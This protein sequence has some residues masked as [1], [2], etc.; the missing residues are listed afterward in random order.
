MK[1]K[2]AFA[3]II[4]LLA[5]CKEKNRYI[6]NQGLIY[7]TIYHITYQS[8]NGNDL[9][10]GIEAVL[11][12]IGNSV[13]TFIPSATISKVN[14][15]EDT[16]LDP[17]FLTVFNKAQEVSRITD[18]AF[19]VTVMPMVNAWGF[20]F[21]NKEKVTPELIDSLKQLVGYQ[22]VRIENGKFVKDHPNTM[23]DFSAIAKGFACD[24]VGQFLQVQGCKNYMVEIGGEVVAKGQNEKGEYW[25]IGIS[26]PDDNEMLG[27]QQLNAIVHLKDMA[28][29]TSGNYRN[30][31]IED[32]I[33]Y[34][35]EIDP[36]TG[37]PARHSVLSTTVLAKDC[38][39]AD[40]FATAFM[41]CGLDKA[42]A[43]A[44]A[45]SDIEVYF[46]YVGEDGKYKSYISP[47]FKSLLIKEFD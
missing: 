7:G 19:D 34:A 26:E 16:K 25:K 6:D 15:N 42:I 29:A 37:Y 27:T 5:S 9:K 31:Y 40:A 35:H 30:Y 13:S 12:T 20:G 38:M 18:G 14:K 28:L 11:D 3:A 45:D 46:I 47:G 33:K 32:G 21:K 1:F 4:L 17:Y 41:V 24:M 22:K 43:I 8:P 36:K 2:I 23:L 44:N 10:Q 39:T